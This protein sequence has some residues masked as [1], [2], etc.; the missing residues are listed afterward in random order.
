[1]DFFEADLFQDDLGQAYCS[2]EVP[3]V[4]IQIHGGKQKDA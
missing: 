1:M 2:H 3:S 4:L